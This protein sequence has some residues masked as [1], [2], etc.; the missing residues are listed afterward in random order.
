MAITRFF[1]RLLASTLLLTTIPPVFAQTITEI[2]TATGDG[3]GNVL[4]GTFAI[5]TD[6]SGNV[7]VSGQDSDNVFKITPAGVV[8]KIIDSAGDGKGN[9]LD[10]PDSLITDTSGNVYVAGFWSSTV[11]KVSPNGM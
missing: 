4:Q 6:T 7:Y 2:I 9:R 1:I 10:L 11:F 5:D 8:S 3:L